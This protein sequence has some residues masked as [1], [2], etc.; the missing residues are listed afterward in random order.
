MNLK[1]KARLAMDPLTKGKETSNGIS[2]PNLIKLPKNLKLLGSSVKVEKGRKEGILTGILYLSPSDSSG[3][4]KNGKP[5]NVCPYATEYCRAGCLGLHSGKMP[6]PTVKNSQLWKTALFFTDQNLFINLIIEEIKKLEIKASKKNLVLAIRLNGTSDIPFVQKW[7]LDRL[8]PNVQFYDYTKSPNAI[9]NYVDSPNYHLTF[10]ANSSKQSMIT[11]NK[12]L[13][14][15][16]SVACIVNEHP[17][18]EQSKIDLSC[19]VLGR[20]RYY[21][22]V[23][24]FDDT[25]ARFLTR[26]MPTLGYLKVKG[27]RKVVKMLGKDVFKV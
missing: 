9:D 18:C 6:T 12:A 15:G 4:L 8:F 27:G 16:L 3:L 13:D 14:K 20:Y 17:A 10:S 2:S 24:D 19:M 21:L 5:L 11:S 1:E 22:N 26:E 23:E 25:D 7:K